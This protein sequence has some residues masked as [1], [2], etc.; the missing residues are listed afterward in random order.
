VTAIDL[1]A[2]AAAEVEAAVAVVIIAD[3]DTGVAVEVVAEI[4]TV[5]AGDHHHL[6]IGTAPQALHLVRPTP[7]KYHLR[8][9]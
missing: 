3:Q 9:L 1:R 8:L 4:V 7:M 2:E 6:T 5:T